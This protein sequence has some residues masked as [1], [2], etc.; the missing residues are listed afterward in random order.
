MGDP[1]KSDVA[2]MIARLGNTSMEVC[3]VEQRLHAKPRNAR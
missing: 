3:A 2:G 1:A